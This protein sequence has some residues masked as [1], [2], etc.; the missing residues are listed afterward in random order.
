MGGDPEG[1]HGFYLIVME[2]GEV[3]KVL[4]E[5]LEEE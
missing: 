5:G 2:I 3:Q 4:E 1:S